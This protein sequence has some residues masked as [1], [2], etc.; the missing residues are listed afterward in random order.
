[1]HRS[2]SRPYDQPVDAGEHGLFGQ[3]RFAETLNKQLRV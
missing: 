2:K 1:M 3:A